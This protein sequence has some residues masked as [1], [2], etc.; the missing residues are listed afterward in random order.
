MRR[1]HEERDVPGESF[2]QGAD[3]YA[4]GGKAAS[5]GANGEALAYRIA[6]YWDVKPRLWAIC[7]DSVAAWSPRPHARLPCN[8]V[9][10]SAWKSRWRDALPPV[11]PTESGLPAQSASLL[12][13]TSHTTKRGLVWETQAL[14]GLKR[15]P[16]RAQDAPRRG[17][18]GWIDCF[19]ISLLNSACRAFERRWRSVLQERIYGEAGE[20]C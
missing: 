2:A 7:Q 13:G 11:A 5:L 8:F 12:C 4:T 19:F 6:G 15:C 10:H 17:K 16:D 3:L 14:R 18:S 9:R 1:R 20:R